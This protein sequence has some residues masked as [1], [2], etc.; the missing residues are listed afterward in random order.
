ML[1]WTLGHNLQLLAVRACFSSRHVPESC[2]YIATIERAGPSGASN[3]SKGLARGRPGSAG[4]LTRVRAPACVSARVEDLDFSGVF[5]LGGQ[6]REAGKV[7][8]R[9]RQA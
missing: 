4:V 5:R 9:P 8:D 1:L 2:L 7:E 3:G 6:R